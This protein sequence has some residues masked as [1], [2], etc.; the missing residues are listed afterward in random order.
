MTAVNKFQKDENAICGSYF[1]DLYL[2]RFPS[3][4]VDRNHVID[5]RIDKI[6][7]ID[8]ALTRSFSAHTSMVQCVEIFGTH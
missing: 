5:F 8:M 6:K 7:K 4:F 1:G 3:M 2:F